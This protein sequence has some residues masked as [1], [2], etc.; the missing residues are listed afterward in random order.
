MCVNYTNLDRVCTKDAHPPPNIDKLGDN[1]SG[2]KLLSFM[3]L[4]MGTNQM[5]MAKIDKEKITFMLNQ[6]II[7]TT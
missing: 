3:E 4:I 7:T 1:S 2:F 6:G 5:S